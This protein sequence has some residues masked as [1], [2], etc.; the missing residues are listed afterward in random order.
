MARLDHSNCSPKRYPE[1][2]DPRGCQQI[3]RP[4]FIKEACLKF[5]AWKRLEKGHNMIRL[6]KKIEFY[7]FKSCILGDM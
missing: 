4:V 3:N 2:I 1:I 7:N 6:Y 5:S